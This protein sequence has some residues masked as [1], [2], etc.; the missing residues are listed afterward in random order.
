MLNYNITPHYTY[1]VFSP[2]CDNILHDYL[3]TYSFL[4]TPSAICFKQN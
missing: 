1:R 3:T 4:L 2:F